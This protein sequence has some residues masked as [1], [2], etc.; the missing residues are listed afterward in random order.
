YTTWEL[1]EKHDMNV[2]K[3]WPGELLDLVGKRFLFKL[4]YSDY[5]VNNNHT[6][7]CDAVNDEPAFVKHFKE[8]FLDEEDD[9]EGFTTPASQIK[10]TNFSDPSLSR[11]LDMQTPTS[12]NEAS[13]SFEQLFDVESKDDSQDVDG[14]TD[15]T[16]YNLTHSNDIEDDINDEN[17][18]SNSFIDNGSLDDGSTEDDNDSDS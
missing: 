10:V 14:I 3:Y 7:R 11:V 5:N 9:D 2:D 12:E 13:G 15:Q 17:D 6:Y 8:G 1:M 4:Y 18:Y 16:T